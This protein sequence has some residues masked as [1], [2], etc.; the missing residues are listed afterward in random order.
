MTGRFIALI[1]AMGMAIALA[2]TPALAKHGAT[3]VEQAGRVLTL[4]S[5]ACQDQAGP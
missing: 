4:G 2:G 3:A 1:G 5:A